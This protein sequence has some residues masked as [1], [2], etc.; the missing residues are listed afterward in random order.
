MDREEKEEEKELVKLTMKEI[1]LSFVDVGMKINEICGY[2]VHR[3]IAR[4]YFRSRDADKIN[5]AKKLWELE[6]HGYI[7]RYLREKEH[8]IE[9]TPIGE[10]K[11]LKYLADEFRVETPK[12]WDKKWRLVIFDIPKDKKLL[13][14][15]LR[16]RLKRIGFHQLQKSVFIYPYDCWEQIKALKYIYGLGAYLQYIVAEN[17]E[18]EID[19]IDYFYTAGILNNP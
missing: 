17:I 1:L 14:D 18:T 6:K 16:T 10:E 9:L 3:Q 13:R 2:R 11:A 7:K 12:T 5:L 15:I 4:D 19:L 8:I